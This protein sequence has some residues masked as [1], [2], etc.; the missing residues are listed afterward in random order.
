LHK[1]DEKNCLGIE[2]YAK[3]KEN[4]IFYVVKSL[5]FVDHLVV[6]KEKQYW[7]YSTSG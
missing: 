7:Y 6:C 3:V 5:P 2:K 1:N 4:P